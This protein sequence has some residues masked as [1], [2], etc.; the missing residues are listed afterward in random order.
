MKNTIHSWLP[1]LKDTRHL[2]GQMYH[3]SVQA[4]LGFFKPSLLR[5][6]TSTTSKSSIDE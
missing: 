2:G 5:S 3:L 1:T 6:K 4:K